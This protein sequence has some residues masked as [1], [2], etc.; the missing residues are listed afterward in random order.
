MTHDL[1]SWRAM[2]AS[3]L[4]GVTEAEGRRLLD[5]ARVGLDAPI[6]ACPPWRVSDLLGHL[7]S[8]YRRTT[9]VLA[10]RLTERPAGSDWY[11]VPPP[12][13]AVY[14]WF[15]TSLTDVV[16][17]LARVDPTTPSWTFSGDHRTAG[18]W[19]RRLA[20]ETTVH[21][22]DVES[23]HGPPTPVPAAVAVDGIDEAFDVMIA[24]GLSGRF[25]GDDGSVHLHATDVP[26][27]WLVGL[28]PEGVV[29]ER[30][31]GKG[32]A[33]VRGPA[34]DLFLWLWGRVGTDQL[35][36]FGDRALLAQLRSGV[37]SV[38]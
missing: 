4:V 16:T 5:A 19:P 36:T 32:T 23:A 7:A 20:H 15:D 22:T 6:A 34:S 8:V 13:E 27:E 26:G 24:P 25:C 33:A 31:H 35:E 12:G 18:F 3:E 29:V 9:H 14:D 2:E 1:P 30:S 10:H 17:H 21:R 28:G 37:A 38:T 11:A